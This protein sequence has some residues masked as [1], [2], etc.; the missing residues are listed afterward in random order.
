MNFWHFALL[1]FVLLLVFFIATFIHYFKDVKDDTC[2]IKGTSQ[3]KRIKE[4]WKDAAESVLILFLYTFPLL[5][6]V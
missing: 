1:Y 6:I 3:K 2:W 5:F 4:T